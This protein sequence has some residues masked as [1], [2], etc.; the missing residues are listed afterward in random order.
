M[1]LVVPLNTASSQSFSPPQPPSWQLVAWMPGEVRCGGTAIAAAGVRRPFT[2]IRWGTGHATPAAATYRFRIDAAGRP[3][4]IR[5]EGMAAPWSEDVAPSLA[6]SRF[7]A[8]APQADCTIRYTLRATPPEETPVGDLISYSLTPQSG[9]LPPDGWARIQSPTASCLAE[10]RPRPLVAAYPNFDTLPATPGVKHWT[11]VAYDQDSR[12]RPIHVR[13]TQ[14]TGSAALDRAAVRAMRKS[15]FTGGATTGCLYPYWRAPIT[16]AAPEPPAQDALRPVDGNCPHS[17][18]WTTP[19]TLRYPAAYQRRAIEGWAVVAFDVASW[20]ELGNLRVLAS[21]P[22]ADFG[23]QAIHVLRSARKPASATG[24]SG[25]VDRVIFK[26][27]YGGFPP[28]E[29]PA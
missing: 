9:K 17:D 6:A 2:A 25:C 18:D 24:R 27:G 10:P 14:G 20:G 21:E 8:G 7:A 12:G 15:R 13:T 26:M 1:S 28:A 11:M 3:L 23:E 5:R 4:S 22:T 19:P 16:L 29:D